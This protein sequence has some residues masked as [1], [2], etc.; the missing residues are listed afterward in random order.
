MGYKL[1]ISAT[2]FPTRKPGIW[3]NNVFG[4][5]PHSINK[6]SLPIIKMEGAI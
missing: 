5:D 6:F 1:A 4:C 3:T 2:L